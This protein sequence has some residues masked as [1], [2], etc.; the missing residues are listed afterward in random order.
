[1]THQMV[2]NRHGWK[3]LCEK[4]EK[5]TPKL[6][7]MQYILDL[8]CQQGYK[9]ITPSEIFDDVIKDEQTKDLG[10]RT[11]EEIEE[12]KESVGYY[13]WW[14]NPPEWDDID[15]STFSLEKRHR[16]EEEQ[17]LLREHTRK[18][19]IIRLALKGLGIELK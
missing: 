6:V 17:R 11:E 8:S 16:F 14:D 10:G 9:H 12:I 19:Q 13:S 1:M 15:K 2:G 7:L 18:I 4:C 3:F 5:T